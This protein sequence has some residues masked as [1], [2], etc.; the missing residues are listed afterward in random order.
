MAGKI[1][2]KDKGPILF[3]LEERSFTQIT[4]AFK[5]MMYL[6]KIVKTCENGVGLCG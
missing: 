6:V 4:K 2:W 1:L 3:V 5:K